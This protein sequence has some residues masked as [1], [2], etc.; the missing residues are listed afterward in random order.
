MALIKLAADFK[1]F[2]SLCLSHEARFMVIGGYA[3][4]HYSRPRYTGDLDI[5]IDAS[6]ENAH[7]IVAVLRDFGLSGPDITTRLITDKK[8][9]IR[10]GFEPMRLELFTRI[11]ALDFDD[12][13]PRR[14]SVKI[15]KLLVPFI[16]LE[17]LKINKRKSGRP[18]D[19]QDLEELP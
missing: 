3:V 9:I 10:L 13:Y 17:D 18:K 2:L 15:G 1:D 12:C 5:W 7:R 11:P 14:E 4:V 6:E 8:Q 16:S 19:M